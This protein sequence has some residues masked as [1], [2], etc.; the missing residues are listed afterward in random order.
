MPNTLRTI[1]KEV[2]FPGGAYSPV[3]S[4]ADLSTRIRSP[5]TATRLKALGLTEQ[6]VTDLVNE[7]LKY[8]SNNP[9]LLVAP[10]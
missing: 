10:Q 2:L 1:H 4:V 9:D 5:E 7:Y 6:A 3:S 8:Y